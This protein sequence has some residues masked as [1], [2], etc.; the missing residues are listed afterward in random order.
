MSEA[1]SVP[2]GR[3]VARSLGFQVFASESHAPRA[4]RAV[5]ALIV[6]A[7]AVLL[8]GLA[9]VADDSSTLEQSW[10]QLAEA[11]PG[12]LQWLAEVTYFLGALYLIVLIVGVGLVARQRKDLLRD[13]LVAL[14]LSAGLV[15]AL[16]QIVDGEWP[17]VVWFDQSRTASTYPALLITVLTAVHVTA[18]PHL[19]RP[20]R[21]LGWWV[22]LGPAA[23]ALLANLT[24]VRD[25]AAAL[26]A[27]VAVGALAHL[28]FGSPAGRPSLGRVASALAE[29]GVTA[30]DLA[31]VPVQSDAST[32]LSATGS[33]GERLQIEVYGRDAARSQRLSRAWRIAWYRDSPEPSGSGRL[34]LVE[35]AA[36]T[37]LLAG[38]GGARVPYVVAV[39]DAGAGDALLVTSATG[40]R[41]ADLDADE[42]D[43]VLL[44]DAW[45]QLGALHDAGVAHGRPNLDHVDVDETGRVGLSGFD[46]A[47]V[48]PPEAALLTDRAELLTATALAVGDERAVAVAQAALGDD[49]LV[50]SPKP[51]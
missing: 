38:R 20:L 32:G 41:L 45:A 29:L 11:L 37:M 46:V 17:D 25:T 27:G 31:F 6:G 8:V 16:G 51:A 36:L 48:S 7:G 22:V 19:S 33:D 39:G 43:D 23:A 18:A 49:G 9:A 5:D 34:E 10:S 15:V 21:R 2:H 44:G 4:R 24:T 47:Q 3:R 14:V 26:I 50:A 12:W 28:I 30:I 35:H 42:L 40:R 13:L 1:I